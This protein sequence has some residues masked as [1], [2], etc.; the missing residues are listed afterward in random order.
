MFIIKYKDSVILGPMV[1][2][3]LRFIDAIKEEC[4]IEA[5]LPAT[6]VGYY[7]VNDDIKIWP[8]NPNPQEVQVYN[9]MIEYLHG[10]IWDC[11]EGIAT[12][13]YTVEKLPLLAS[14]NFFK[15]KAGT[16]RWE[17]QNSGVKVTLNDVE[18]TFA[19]DL[20]TKSI[21]HQYIT[22]DLESVNWKINQ[23]TWIVLSKSDIQTVFNSI[24]NHVQAAYDWE[25][26]KLS[27]IVNSTYEQLTTLSL[28]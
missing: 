27:E 17:K 4:E 5:S 24:V 26:A 7:E 2:R 10:P 16:I 13:S 22:S 6:N 19:T 14:Q 11:N 20:E 8:V 23:D 12:P 18:Y 9:P 25:V 3:Q 1:W 28:E 21:F 15:Q